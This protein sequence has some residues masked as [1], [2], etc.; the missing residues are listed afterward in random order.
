MKTKFLIFFIF[1]GCFAKSQ[2]E[3]DCMVYGLCSYIN[4]CTVPG[5][6]LVLKFNEDSL[7]TI[8]DNLVLNLPT[9]SGRAAFADK[10]T[11]NLLFASNGW[12]LVNNNGQ[13]LSHKLW[14][15]S[16]PHP[17]E[18][19]D[20]TQLGYLLMGP[21]FLNDPA[22]STKAFLFY[23]QYKRFIPMPWGQIDGADVVFTY[24]YLDIPTRTLISKNHV[25]LDELSVYGDMVATRH[26][27]GRDWWILKSGLLHKEYHRWLL[28]P[29]GFSYDKLIIPEISDTIRRTLTLSYFNMEGNRFITFGSYYGNASRTMYAY[30]FDRCS[31]TLS[32]PVMHD[33]RDSLPQG[34]IY[35][36]CISPDGSKAYIGRSN[37]ISLGIPSA[38]LQYDLNTQNWHYINNFG[39]ASQLSPNGK[40]LYS[41]G[42]IVQN[43][44][45]KIGLSQI[46]NPNEYG[47]A[48]GFQ[49]NKYTTDNATYLLFPSNF[50]NFRLGKLA[51]SPCDTI[52]SSVQTVSQKEVNIQLYPNPARDILYLEFPYPNGKPYQISIVDVMGKVVY[53]ST[54]A[55]EGGSL[56][57]AQLGLAKGLYVL[58][59][60]RDGK[61]Y[62]RRFLIEN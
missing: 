34:Q 10:H 48:C 8:L 21:L 42:D 43:N 29:Q 24:A 40:A 5:Q 16:I 20:S 62:S 44:P 9:G 33:L 22:D 28:S 32:N 56:S 30:D 36:F 31:G 55:A 50:A 37:F 26:A 46:S 47:I 38:S 35:N 13:V 45:F 27:N 57:L 12:R 23:G 17:G 41:S 1:W 49:M 25:L 6:N 19:N 7:E 60:Q 53:S 4:D 58:Q 2:R 59:A 51:G 52:V 54:F 3:A 39:A 14:F 11:G 15:D 18:I 61:G